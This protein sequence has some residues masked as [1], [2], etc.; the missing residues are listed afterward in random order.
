MLAALVLGPV[1]AARG[2][3]DARLMGRLEPIVAERIRLAE[4]GLERLIADGAA[5]ELLGQGHARLAR[6]YHAYE[7]FEEAEVHYRRAA[8]LLPNDQRWPYYLGQ[9]RLRLGRF[10]EA[11]KAFVGASRIA[12][13]FI[14]SRVAAGRARLEAG[15]SRRALETA[16]DVLGTAPDDPAA[17][18]LCAE[19]ASA[20]GEWAESE[21]CYTELLARQPDATRLY[22]P[23]AAAHRALGE[24]ET[25]IRLL[26]RR[27]DGAV[28]LSDPLMEEIRDL[29]TGSRILLNRGITAFQRGRYDDAVGLFRQAVSLDATSLLAR[30]NLA[31]ALRHSGDLAGAE[32]EYGEILRRDPGHVAARYGLGVVLAR[33]GRDAEAVAAYRRVLEID[34][35]HEDSRFNLANSLRRIGS[36]DEAIES[37]RL[38]IAADPTHSAAHAGEALCW[39]AR[40]DDGR[41]LRGV[42]E[43]LAADPHSFLLAQL[44]SRLMAT[45]KDAAVH[46]P[47]QAL[48]L[49]EQ[50]VTARRSLGHL[51]TLAMALAA[52]GRFDA[53]I[54]VQSN[55]LDGASDADTKILERMRRN[56]ELYRAGRPAADAG[57]D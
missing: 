51:E 20:M 22:V 25:A 30:E 10:E 57:L 36:Y 53:A 50:L 35:E 1:A 12:P 34:P 7:F 2:G 41:A 9:V 54:Y 47:E 44:G 5:G 45:S 32:R 19:A 6:L 23:L 21:R 33:T 43:G 48:R 37:Y 42:K 46:D 56:L 11:E 27:G 28:R 52:V 3:L 17:W 55:T 24:R 14:A 29:A 16:R 38:V 39:I 31:V 26:A 15:S 49:A 4:D 18:L 8:E 13:R 40:G